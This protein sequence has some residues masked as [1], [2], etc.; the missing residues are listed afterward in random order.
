LYAIGSI[1]RGE[2][3]S[4]RQSISPPQGR[5]GGA[6]WLDRTAARYFARATTDPALQRAGH[7]SSRLSKIRQS[8]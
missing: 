4:D 8:D 6:P 3:K 1:L 5:G 2:S 7:G